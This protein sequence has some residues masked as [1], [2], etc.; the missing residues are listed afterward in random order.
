MDRR[1]KLLVLGGSAEATALIARLAP[2]VGRDLDLTVSFAG[3]TKHP[4]APAGEIRVGGFGGAEGLERYLRAERVDVLIDALH[5]FAGAMPFHAR[6]AC[7]N[8]G[9]ALLKLQ[10]PPWA[11]TSGDLWIDVADMEEATEVVRSLAPRR[12]LLTIGRQEL[13]PFRSVL[14]PRFLVRSIEPPDLAGPWAAIELLDRGPFSL[15]HERELLRTEGIDLVVTKN[16]G[17]R[18]TSAKLAAARERQAPVVLVRRPPMP[19]TPTVPSV[20]E[21]VVWLDRQLSRLDRPDGSGG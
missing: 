10:R 3:R 2:R 9:V 8:A 18:A 12:V 21:A 7:T 19:D 16:S 15:D 11:P 13:E 14:G 5:P 6:S 4:T 17:G 1:P 20:D